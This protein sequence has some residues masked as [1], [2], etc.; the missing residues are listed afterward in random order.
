ML[1]LVLAVRVSVVET[2][3]PDG[4]TV[5]GEK[6]HDVPASNPE[7]LNETLEVNPFSGVIAI[8]AFPFCPAITVRDAGDAVTEKS[9]G[10]LMV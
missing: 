7:Q 1:A 3:V 2:V 4:V 10:R 6:L 9:G 8:L 5:A